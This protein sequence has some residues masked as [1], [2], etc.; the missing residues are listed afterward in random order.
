MSRKAVYSIILLVLLLPLSAQAMPCHCFS[1]KDF[2]PG[3][4][5]AAD[6]Y[7]LAT[8]QNSFFS[9]VFNIEKKKVVF[10]KQKPRSTAEGLW[11]LNWLALTTG[12][13]PSSLHQGKKVRGSWQGA[14]EEA[15]VKPKSLSLHFQELL[16]TGANDEQLAQYVV[17]DLLKAKGVTTTEEL[18]TLRQAGA[19]N[20]ETILASLLGRKTEKLPSI[21]FQS[22]GRGEITWGTLLLNAGMNGRDMVE[23]IRALLGQ[24]SNAQ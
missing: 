24:D 13:E 2:D 16:Q 14:L 12:K 20:E 7:Y 10:A 17:D 15:G 1:A 6:P 3:E 8:S 9:V 4:P 19:S 18:Q 5:A 23:E 11:V 22:V 21:L